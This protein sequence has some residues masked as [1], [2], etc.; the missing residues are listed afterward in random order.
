ML[1]LTRRA[2]AGDQSIITIG[3]GI[4]ITVLSVRGGQVRIGVAAPRAL[5][6]HRDGDALPVHRDAPSSPSPPPP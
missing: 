4:E 3:E 1:V 5:P 2:D 6:V